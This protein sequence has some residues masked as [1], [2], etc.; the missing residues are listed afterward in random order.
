[1]PGCNVFCGALLLSTFLFSITAKAQVP[2]EEIAPLPTELSP[3]RMAAM[4]LLF[5]KPPTTM[6]ATPWRPRRFFVYS[7]RHPLTPR[8]VAVRKSVRVLGTDKHHFVR[9]E[10]KNHTVVTGA[11]TH[12]DNE[13]FIVR[14]GILDSSGYR[15][16]YRE[17]SA[18]PRQVAAVGEHMKNGLEWT[19]LVGMCVV[20]LPL[21]LVFYPLVIAGVI[22]D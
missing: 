13:G 3:G 12:I 21:A 1:M 7:L 18:P 8:D 19:G 11:I 5:P 20:L 17:L 6:T 10:L 4:R 15:V 2:T 16:P 22:Q 9:C 14:T